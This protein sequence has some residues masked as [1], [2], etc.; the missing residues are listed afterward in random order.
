M[1]L[2]PPLIIFACQEKATTSVNVTVK[3]VNTS[4]NMSVN[5]LQ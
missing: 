4:V 1:D 2:D 5:R 3:C